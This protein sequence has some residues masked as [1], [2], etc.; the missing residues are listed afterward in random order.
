MGQIRKR[1]RRGISG[2]LSI[3]ILLQ[4]T[5]LL[6]LFSYV[7]TECMK[8]MYFKQGRDENYL[9]KLV[10]LHRIKE[11]SQRFVVC[12][13]CC[14]EYS[15][16]NTTIWFPFYTPTYIHGVYYMGCNDTNVLF[17]YYPSVPIAWG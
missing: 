6:A 17:A 12:F 5:L 4:I 1:N 2:A 9:I 8:F 14:V 13:H 15:Y 11:D 7:I 16:L 10:M 3:I